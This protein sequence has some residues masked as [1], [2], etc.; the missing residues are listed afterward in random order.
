MRSDAASVVA[1]AL[2]EVGWHHEGF[3]VAASRP[4]GMRGFL[5]LLELRRRG[6]GGQ[7]GEAVTMAE[8]KK[9]VFSGIQPSGNLHIG[10]YLGAIR[11]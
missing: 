8:R 2:L 6:T 4:V 7:G 9:R 1:G 5:F 11:N 10:N 3:V